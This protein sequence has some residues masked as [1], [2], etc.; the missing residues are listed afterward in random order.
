M[1][2]GQRLEEASSG[3]ILSMVREASSF[4]AEKS[5]VEPALKI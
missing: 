5:E 4:D 2:Q 3:R 1:E